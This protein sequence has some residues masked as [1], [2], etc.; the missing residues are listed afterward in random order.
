M[1]TTRVA[2]LELL[3]RTE[4]KWLVSASIVS[5]RHLDS[6]PFARAC[7]CVQ[8]VARTEKEL[9]MFLGGPSLALTRLIEYLNF[10]LIFLCV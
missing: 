8:N 3:F 5:H 6:T 2:Q 4:V 7:P 1:T 9:C 10:V